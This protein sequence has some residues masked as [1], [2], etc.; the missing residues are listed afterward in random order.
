MKRTH[1]KMLL[2]AFT[3]LLFSGCAT[4]QQNTLMSSTNPTV[5]SQIDLA[6][7]QMK[8]RNEIQ[9]SIKNGLI[10]IRKGDFDKASDIFE[11]G[12]RLSSTNGHLHFLNALA[13]HMNSLS[14]SSKMLSLAEA[15]YTTALRFDKS[16]YLAAYLLGHIYFEQKKVS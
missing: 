1:E 2:G 12:L 8:P 11:K 16:N 3:V 5:S 6:F 15:G 4:M 10:E 14:G 7:A 9:E 13:Y